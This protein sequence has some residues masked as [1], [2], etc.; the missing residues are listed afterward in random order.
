MQIKLVT[1][2]V[3]QWEIFFHLLHSCDG[4]MYL[5]HAGIYSPSILITIILHSFS[6]L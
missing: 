1:V 5:C 2:Q 3:K 6:I 4:V